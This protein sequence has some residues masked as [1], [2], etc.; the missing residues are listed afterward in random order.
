M[1]VKYL[2]ALVLFMG[3]SLSCSNV[4]VSSQPVKTDTTIAS[5]VYE[6]KDIMASDMAFIPATNNVVINHAVDVLIVDFKKNKIIKKIPSP[7]PDDLIQHIEVSKQGDRLLIAT[8]TAAQVWDL[9]ALTLIASFTSKKK[10]RLSGLSPDGEKLVFDQHIFDIS[11]RK[12][13]M[14]FEPDRVPFSL[15]FSGE[16]RYLVTDG[17]IS[18]ASV[19]DIKSKK[20]LKTI[21]ENGMQQIRF[22]DFRSFYIAAG[23]K[24]LPKS[25]GYYSD[26]ISLYS[27]DDLK[28]SHHYTSSKRISCW[29]KLFDNKILVTKID[30]SIDLLTPQLLSEKTWTPGIK[31]TACV[32]GT[33]HRVWMASEKSGVYLLN[34]KSGEIIKFIEAINDPAHL[35]LSDDNKYLGIVKSVKD[36]SHINIFSIPN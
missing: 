9:K 27:L 20:Q 35:I 2:S 17:H 23:S 14:E 12:T 4:S 33:A 13:I 18:G 22:K 24:L 32:S 5:L 26:A 15:A 3:L 6:F 16:G 25:G 1:P 29:D 21:F 31:I 7:E 10:S 28:R 8:P 30:G 11:S 34:I 19:I 36:G